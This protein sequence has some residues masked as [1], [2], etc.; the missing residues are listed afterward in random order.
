MAYSLRVE[1][2]NSGQIVVGENN[3]VINAADGSSITL[4]EG[5]P[6]VV[7]KRTRPVARPL[8]RRGPNLI[9][10]D[11]ELDRIDRAVAEGRPV[12]VSGPPGCG[13]S[14]LLRH[15]ALRRA[16]SG[17]DVVFLSAAGLDPRDLVQ[18]LFQACYDADDYL[19]DPDRLRRLM[20]SIKAVVVVDDFDGS[21]EDAAALLDACPACDVIVASRRP[22][23]FAG[24]TAIVLEGLSQADSSALLT[25]ELG[26][27]LLPDET[28]PAE[29]L[30]Q[31][32]GGCPLAL[33][34]AVAAL[35]SSARLTLDATPPVLASA[36]ASRLTEPARRTLSLLAA[37]TDVEVP[38]ACL[39]ALAAGD[40]ALAELRDARLLASGPVGHRVAGDLAVLVAEQVAARPNPETLAAELVTWM[41]GR[42]TL[43]DIADAGP[44]ILQVLR[45]CT[46]QEQ[47]AAVVTLA[48]ITAPVLQRTLRWGGWREVL[49]L[50]RTSSQRI[51]SAADEAYFAQEDTIR[52]KALGVG[53]ATGAAI[54]GAYSAA[55]SGA[56]TTGSRTNG[57]ADTM[58][59][60]PTAPAVVGTAAAA[61][62]V[63]AI[64]GAVA[65]AGESGPRSTETVARATTVPTT[66]RPIPTPPTSVRVIA[67]PTTTPPPVFDQQPTN[68][69]TIGTPG[70]AGG[71]AP[72][73][74]EF[75]TVPVGRT[76]VVPWTFT[77]GTCWPPEGANTA[78]MRIEGQGFTFTRNP[79]T[80]PSPLPRFG[81]CDVDITFRPVAGRTDYTALLF[82]PEMGAPNKGAEQP[83]HGQAAT[84]PS[85]K[86]QNTTSGTPTS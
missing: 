32:S 15:V 5:R 40:S 78:A 6:P 8:P 27:S 19:P 86:P 21:P 51:G 33:V 48:R 61:I 43:R 44:V 83:L 16:A 13:K 1:S 23:A 9:G 62:T 3:I 69:P 53:L 34:Q 42:A 79:A 10:R 45:L 67:G 24:G 57:P 29:Q 76:S 28:G 84:S 18:E 66:T 63:A 11:D 2:A 49:A 74:L 38:D 36:L 80:C 25:A 30:W 58:R 77:L 71:G 82:V 59:S 72:E 46:A 50:G 81:S 14:A 70:C 4:H 37:L 17:E 54:G 26:R 47:H 75:E 85:S 35:K 60:G 55:T 68:E 12:R 56:T 22:G 73:P 52:R 65:L 39:I 41:R 20:G 7:R 64:V 31:T